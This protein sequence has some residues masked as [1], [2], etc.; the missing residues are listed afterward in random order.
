MTNY[1][2]FKNK[3]VLITGGTGSFGSMFLKNISLKSYKEILVISRDEDKQ[4]TLRYN[5]KNKNNIKFIIGNVSNKDSISN[6][7]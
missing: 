3:R 7:L 4:H 6:W 2:I 1:N 5:Y